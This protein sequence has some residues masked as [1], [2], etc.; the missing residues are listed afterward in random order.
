MRK[1][2]IGDWI[3]LFGAGQAMCYIEQVNVYMPDTE[4]PYFI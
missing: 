4:S 2:D 1:L 3:Q